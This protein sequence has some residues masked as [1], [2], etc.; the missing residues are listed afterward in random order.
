MVDDG[1]DI[2]KGVDHPGPGGFQL[3]TAE[4]GEGFGEGVLDVAERLEVRR[5]VQD[6][7]GLKRGG[8]I[9][10]PAAGGSPGVGKERKASG[11]MK[12]SCSDPPG[13]RE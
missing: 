4:G 6:A 3:R 11:P 8:V 1:D 7:G 2:W 9:L 12:K 13:A 5:G 10:G